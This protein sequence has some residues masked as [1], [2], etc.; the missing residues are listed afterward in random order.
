VQLTGAETGVISRQDGEVY[1]AVAIY[2]PHPEFIE[3]AKQNPIPQDR[4]LIVYCEREKPSC[5]LP[6]K[7]ALT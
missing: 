5:S 1:R 2:D 3:I 7:S 4:Q 6:L